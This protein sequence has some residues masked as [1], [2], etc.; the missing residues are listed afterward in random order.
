MN[1]HY[2]GAELHDNEIF[3]RNCGT[4][5][6][7]EEKTAPV[8]VAVPEEAPVIPAAAEAPAPR[9]ME[10]KEKTFDWQPYGAPAKE[11]SLI[12]LNSHAPA[13]RLPVKRSLVKM[14]FL[15]IVTLGIYPLVIW[16]RLTGEVNLV[17]SRY[18]GQR[19]MPFLGMVMLSPLTLG[20]HSLVWMNKLC[21]RISNE[22]QR[23]CISYNFGAKDFWLWAFLLSGLGS[24]CAGV[25][26]VIATTGSEAYVILWILIAVTLLTCIGPMIFIAK[27]MNAMNRL[28]EDFNIN[29]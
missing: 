28:N 14:I 13:L 19:S 6:E 20:I 15:G 23:R 17:A 5:R 7:I 2:C 22:L 18:D 9:P 24:I 29:G 21:N 10:Y 3:C 27:L 26:T 8:P 4:R 12:N 25:C 16:S 1:C 11:E